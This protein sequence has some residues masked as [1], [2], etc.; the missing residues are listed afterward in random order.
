WLYMWCLSEKAIAP[1]CTMEGRQT[2]R[3]RVMLWAMFCWETLGPGINV[4]VILTGTTYLNIV[5]DQSHTFMT[6][7][8]PNRD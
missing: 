7:I 3:G 8:F 1:G 4:N 2:S 5:S 6:T